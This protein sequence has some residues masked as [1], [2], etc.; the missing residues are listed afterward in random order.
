M[1]TH[2]GTLCP[3]PVMVDSGPH[4]AEV[5]PAKG[6]VAHISLCLNYSEHC[7]HP[8]MQHINITLTT[9]FHYSHKSSRNKYTPF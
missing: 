1:L 6:S 2:V 5:L 8:H 7:T 9:K 3:E 4:D